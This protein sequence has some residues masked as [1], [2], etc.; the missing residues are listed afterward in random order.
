[1]GSSF[2]I[3]NFQGILGDV[4]HSTVEQNLA[5]NVTT[6]D[7]ESLRNELRKIGLNSVEVDELEKAVNSDP[8]P[9]SRERFGPAVSAWLGMTLQ[10]AAQGAYDLTIGTAGGVI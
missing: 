10:K 6:G 9:K 8:P 2:N 1:M 5:L 7:F 3:Q 4:I